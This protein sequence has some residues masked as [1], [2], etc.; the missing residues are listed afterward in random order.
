M[1]YQIRIARRAEKAILALPQD[2]YNRI[3]AAME[4]LE[5]DPRP[6]GVKKLRGVTD[7]NRVRVGNYRMI[8]VIDDRSRTIDV[9]EVG[10][11]KDV[12]H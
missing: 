3:R 7:T 1:P 2:A 12:Y 4:R 6:S 11:R 5:D 10:D 9:L 8:N